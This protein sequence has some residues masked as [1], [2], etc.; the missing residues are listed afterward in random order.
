MLCT[1]TQSECYALK[2][3]T[4]VMQRVFFCSIVLLYVSVRMNSGRVL[5]V[6]DTSSLYRMGQTHA[7]HIVRLCCV[8]VCRRVPSLIHS[9]ASLS[10]RTRPCK[11]LYNKGAMHACLCVCVCVCACVC[12][13][14]PSLT[15]SSAFH[16]IRRASVLQAH[17][18]G[19]FC[20]R[21]RM[22]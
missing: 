15:H 13:R 18:P 20:V 9:S 12:R 7:Q 11:S 21:F 14:V 8:C 6:G 3:V 22:Q 16:C 4:C 17:T 1:K 10:Q 19:R 5:R 2:S